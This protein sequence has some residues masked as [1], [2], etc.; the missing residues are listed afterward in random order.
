[1]RKLILMCDRCHSEPPESKLETVKIT[2]ENASA[3]EFYT[4]ELCPVCR[5]D[6]IKRVQQFSDAPELVSALNAIIPGH[7]HGSKG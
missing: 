6:F 3:P 4:L 7:K 2:V 1:M 5:Q